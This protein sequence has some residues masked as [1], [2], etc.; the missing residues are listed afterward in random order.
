[1]LIIFSSESKLANDYTWICEI[2]HF[3]LKNNKNVVEGLNYAVYDMA[4]L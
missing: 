3:K 2:S 4:S 1:M